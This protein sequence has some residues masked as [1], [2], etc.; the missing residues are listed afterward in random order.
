V[1]CF[2]LAIVRLIKLVKQIRS[3]RL[4]RPTGPS[5]LARVTWEEPAIGPVISNRPMED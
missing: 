5:R 2:E 4:A 1:M 3:I